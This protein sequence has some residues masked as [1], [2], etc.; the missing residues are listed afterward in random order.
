MVALAKL[1]FY[2]SALA[3]F[4]KICIQGFFIISGA[5]VYGSYT[6]TPSLGQYFE[7]RIRRIYPAYAVIIL[8]PA[9]I[10]FFMGGNLIGILKYVSANLVFMN[11]L[12]PTLPGFFVGHDFTAVNGALWTLKIEFMFYLIVPL[13]AFMIAKAGKSRWTLIICI[14]TLAELWRYG[15]DQSL[16][17]LPSFLSGYSEIIAR[18]LPGQMSFFVTGIALWL[19][20]DHAKTTRWAYVVA[21]SALIGLSLIRPEFEFLR[22]VGLGLV[23]SFIAFAKGPKLNASHWGDLSYG[24][25]ITHFPIIQLFIS[26]GLFATQ[27]T[28]AIGLV[29]ILAF[30]ASFFLWHLIEKPSLHT[31]SHYRKTVTV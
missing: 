28:L 8:V 21:G 13:L 19:L 17:P 6:R 29:I 7:K 31:S 25:Y 23:I 5:L 4:G 30:A 16:I 24:L 18:Q 9:L 3:E 20:W 12:A 27:P 22:G 2:E 10:C 14:Y 26:V 15:F 1:G 11:F